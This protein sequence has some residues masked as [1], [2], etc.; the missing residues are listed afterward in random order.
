[1]LEQ[2]Y[3]QTLKSPKLK[4]EGVL[5]RGKVS[6]EWCDDYPEVSKWLPWGAAINMKF[7]AGGY[8]KEEHYLEL[9]MRHKEDIY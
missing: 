8:L 6:H 1:M 2:S 7:K 3:I 9:A 4:T 5:E